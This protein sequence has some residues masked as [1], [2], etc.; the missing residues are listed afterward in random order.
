MST[1]DEMSITP[2]T[3]RALSAEVELGDSER[4]EQSGTTQVHI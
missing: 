1:L 2:K 4:S 3:M